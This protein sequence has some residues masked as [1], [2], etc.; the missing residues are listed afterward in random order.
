MSAV[1]AGGGDRA[2]G[3]RG[4]EAP[5]WSTRLLRSELRLIAGRRRNQMGLLVLASVPIV[6][7]DRGQGV[8]AGTDWAL[9]RTSSVVDHLQRPVRA[10]GRP[11]AWRFGMFLPLAIPAM[12][13]GDA[14]A[15]EANIGTLRYLLTVPVQ[16]TRLL[17][18]EVRRGRSSSRSSATALVALVGTIMGL[19]LFGGGDMTTLSGSRVSMAVG[20]RPAAA[21]RALPV[22]AVRRAGGDRSVHL[23]PDRATDRGDDRRRAGQR[24]DV[25]PELDRPAQPGCTRSCSSTGGRRSATSSAT[26]LGPNRCSAG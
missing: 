14:V 15:G 23:D 24:V 21:E 1:E 8:G 9:V 4:G 18:G 13:A 7:A 2:T 10:A 11:G 16:R 17:A 6:M 25:H 22:G 5:G 3:G 12:L 26:R 19:V 20:A